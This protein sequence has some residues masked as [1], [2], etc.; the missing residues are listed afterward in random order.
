MEITINFMNCRGF[1]AI[2]I[3][4]GTLSLSTLQDQND[5]RLNELKQLIKNLSNDD[6]QV[7]ESSQI[8]IVKLIT[9]EASAKKD[10]KKLLAELKATINQG[11]DQEVKSRLE[12]VIKL[13]RQGNWKKMAPSPLE[14]RAVHTA[15]VSGDKLIIWGGLGRN[16]E[17]YNNGALY[18]MG[19]DTWG[20][21]KD[22]LLEG[23][24]G[25]TAVVSGDKLVIW[26]G[27]R[28]DFKTFNDGAIYDIGKDAW[29]KIK[30]GPLDSRT[31]H[32]AVVLANKMIIWGG[33]AGFG[34]K[35]GT[36]DLNDGA[37]YDISKDSWVK[38]KKSPLSGR[39]H[40]TAVL[41]DDK[42]IIW[43][44]INILL[45]TYNDGAIYDV[46]KDSWKKL[47][48]G[49]LESRVSHGAAAAE[50]KM[51][52]W[53][54]GGIDSQAAFNDGAIYD[55]KKDTWTKVKDSP[56]NGR[57]SYAAAASGD[58]LVIWGGYSGGG[59]GGRDYNDGGIYNMTKDRW[60]KLDSSPLGPRSGNTA[61]ICGEK[62][63]IWGGNDLGKTF[64]D[65]A[66]YELPIVWDE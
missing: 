58:K 26:G 2:L 30:A 25:H 54:G 11:K 6:P 3:L 37:I 48:A 16:Q 1:C 39:Y 23:R 31:S 33:D 47:K 43:G 65:G 38:I 24:W 5:P 57:E 60:T 7:R 63:I 20:K 42:L 17:A 61:V 21:M 14:G 45:K 64:N 53:G 27:Q 12:A 66:I 13:L 44:G 46:E 18:D 8:S 28:P 62:L 52:I 40:H 34:S 59:T 50:N 15:I 49:P 36:R 55:M 10:T 4:F 29:T 51:I 22:S 35:D 41:I 19:K 9:Q 56:I 32:T